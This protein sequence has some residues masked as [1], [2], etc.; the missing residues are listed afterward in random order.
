MSEMN[1]NINDLI[2]NESQESKTTFDLPIGL[3]TID[4]FL[5]L[6]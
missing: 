5:T 2:P 3:R 1:E 6:N 4:R